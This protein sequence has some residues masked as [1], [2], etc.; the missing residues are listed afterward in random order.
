MTGPKI[1][2]QCRKLAYPGRA[3]CWEHAGRPLSST[4]PDWEPEDKDVDNFGA[5]WERPGPGEE[6]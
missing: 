5:G 3:L 4:E 1:C 6:D 2:R